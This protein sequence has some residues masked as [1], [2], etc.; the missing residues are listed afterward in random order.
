M[1]VCEAN[2]EKKTKNDGLY[3]RLYVPDD[4]KNKKWWFLCMYVCMCK[5]K[6]SVMVCF[7]FFA[8]FP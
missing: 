6:P 3:V 4:E 5:A 7:D 1:Y 2:D 8:P